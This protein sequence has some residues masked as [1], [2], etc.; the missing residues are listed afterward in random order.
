MRHERDELVLQLVELA[1]ALVLL[2]Q[3]S[4]HRLG[5]GASSPLG[6]QYAPALFG[7]LVEQAVVGLELAGDAAE[8]R[9]ERD[10]HREEGEREDQ[11]EALARAG[12][13]DGDGL[14]VLVELDCAEGLQIGS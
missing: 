2:G 8:D 12:R 9:E 4:L 14:V 3:Q 13:A 5:L 1:Q 10:P 6:L 7:Q 11:G